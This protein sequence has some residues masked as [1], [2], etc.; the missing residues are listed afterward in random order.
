MKAAFA[1]NK[2]YRKCAR[3]VG[4]AMGKYHPHGDSSIYDALARMTQDWAMR[5]PLIDGQGNFGSMD[6]DTPAAMRYTEARLAKPAE[7]LL[8]NIEEDTVTFQPNYDASEREPQVLPARFPESAGQ[9]RRAGSRSGWR[10]TS[11]RT[12]WAKWSM[13]V[14]RISTMA[15]VTIEELT[16]IVPGP[17]FPTGGII[18]GQHGVR[19]ALCHRAA[20]RWC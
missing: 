4:D 9:W 2:P 3:I 16:A 17:D 11:R 19:S 6:P 15:R 20:A 14:W 1:S 7:A 13:P 18:L 8:A 5:V 12:I 10:P